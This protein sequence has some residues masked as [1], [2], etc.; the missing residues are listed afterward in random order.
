MRLIKNDLE[1][2]KHEAEN[3]V[4]SIKSIEQGNFV[5]E[6]TSINRTQLLTSMKSSVLIMLYNAIESTITRCLSKVYEVI[7]Q[8]TIKYNELIPDIQKIVL[9]YYENAILNCSDTNGKASL[10]FEEIEL[11]NGNNDFMFSFDD[12]SKNY[13]MYSGN[14]DSKQIK[15][16]FEKHGVTFEKKCSEAQTIKD[17]RNQLAHGEKSFEE[18]G[19]D[20]S[21]QQ[22]D[23][24]CEKIFD[25]LDSV[26][27]K[28]ID[29]VEHKEFKKTT[30]APESTAV[31][32]Q[33]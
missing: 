12:I 6:D 10:K 30:A 7:K 24:Y 13:S 26:I 32:P 14:L 8:S 2:R 5:T 18:V 21:S 11:I 16:I 33:I 31:D 1:I 4:Q 20:V 19:R 25:Y 27:D 9:V 29:Y 22:L 3:Y 28:F 17:Y 23:V 15:K